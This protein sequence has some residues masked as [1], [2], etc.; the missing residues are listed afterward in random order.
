[1][2]PS[3]RLAPA[4]GRVYPCPDAAAGSTARPAAH[5]NR[6]PTAAMIYRVA[7]VSFLNTL[8]LIERFLD[9]RDPRV[10]LTRALPALL[11]DE[12]AAGRAD[13]ALLPVAEILRGRSGGLLAPGWGI[14]CRGAVDS[15]KLFVHGDPARLKRVRADRAS[16]SSVALLQVLL[17]ERW[18]AAPGFVEA[19]PVPGQFPEA[20]EG[21][22]AIGDRCFAYE[23]ALRAAGQADVQSVD[24]GAAWFDL[25]GLPFVFAAWAVAPD[26]VARAG[27]AGVRG[28]A[29]LLDE[30][31]A[32]GYARRAEIA[33][34]E[35]AAGRLGP[36]GEA[37]AAAITYYFERSLHFRLGDDDL[38]GIARF[39]E[40]CLHQGVLPAGTAPLS[41]V[42]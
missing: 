8:P 6:D 31:L 10:V 40:L 33:A 22:L 15:V 25:T 7:A 34:R 3:G 21:V 29:A 38:A 39:R 23:R 19:E 12:L 20:G 11:A 30:A 24:L 18:G 32:D 28:L 5:P 2:A 27:T 17:A 4:R 16:R 13:V 1:M 26:F 35:G 42:R 37:G 36:G 9:G 14:A 41:L